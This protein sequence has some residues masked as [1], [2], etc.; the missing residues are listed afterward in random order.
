MKKR[1]NGKIIIIFL[2][3]LQ[4]ISLSQGLCAGIPNDQRGIGIKAKDTET[5]K[6]HD[7]TLYRKMHAVIIG[8]DKYQY[9]PLDKQLSYA[10]NDAKGVEKVLREKY[11]FDNDNIYTLYN[12]RATKFEILKILVGELSKIDEEDAVFV[13]FA[14]HGT[15][16]EV[17]KKEKRQIDYIIPYDGTFKQDEMYRNISLS[18][19]KNDVGEVIPAKHLFYVLDSCYSGALLANTRSGG[20]NPEH[21]Y[22]YLKESTSKPIRQAFTAGAD[23]QTVL[24]GGPK[25]HSVFTGRFIERLEEAKDYITAK[26][27]GR[28]V[29][30]SVISDAE[31]RG[32]KQTPRIGKFSGDDGGDFVFVPKIR[33]FKPEKKSDSSGGKLFF[34]KDFTPKEKSVLSI[35]ADPKGKVI[36]VGGI[37]GVELFDAVTGKHLRSFENG[38]SVSLQFSPDGEKLVMGGYKKI[39]IGDVSTG[40]RVDLPTQ[41]TDFVVSLTFSPDGSALVSG[42]KGSDRT[43]EI[44]DLND[45]KIIRIL[46]REHDNPEEIKFIQ[47]SPDGKL[48]AASSL[49]D[50]EIVKI[51]NMENNQLWR[52]LDLP[53]NEKS[54]GEVV[55]SMAFSPDSKYL[56]AGL[57][58]GNILVHDISFNLTNTFR[59]HSK[60]VIGIGFTKDSRY[61]ISGGRD[62]LIKYSDIKY[63]TLEL[64]QNIDEE[65][66]LLQIIPNTEV[67]KTEVIKTGMI[68]TSG[69]SKAYKYILPDLR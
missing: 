65:F 54:T 55:K 64:E 44:I 38:T 60:P 49:N 40:Q 47:F 2:A 51:W 16:L 10:V 26:T 63:N 37:H 46:K 27:L 7:V 45:K 13:F 36:A 19:L 34:E 42:S 21:E 15:T 22:A 61:L 1:I 29:T 59:I 23:G 53:D 12:E 68:I 39:Y 50:K 4:S 28:E 56:A 48:L 66:D 30:G 35:A 67:I 14:G 24:D 43:I 57:S 3:I 11:R 69:N 5:G 17:G 31:E 62:N 33:G 8:I 32:H 20:I 58:S 9:L 41:H 25:G 6:V 18:E 52:T